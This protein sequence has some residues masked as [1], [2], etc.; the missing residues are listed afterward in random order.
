MR[1][2]LDDFAEKVSELGSKALI[3]ALQK[4][5][6]DFNNQL[7]EQ[8]GDNFKQLN[9]AVEKLV[10]WQQQYKDELDKLQSVQ[11]Q[12]SEDLA[13]SDSIFKDLVAKAASYTQSAESLSKLL[14][15]F[16]LQY[17]SM[18]Q[19]QEALLSILNSMKEVEP[20]FSK[21]LLDLTDVFKTGTTNITEHVQT[22]VK[23]LGEQLKTKNDE[24]AEIVK[25]MVPEI[26][27]QVNDQILQ[28]QKQLDENFK[29]LDANLEDELQK[30]L[31]GL[32]RQLAS[33]SEKF[34]SDYS[35][36]TEKL[37]KIVEISKGV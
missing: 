9:L 28:S 30:S 5:I 26:Q 2:S 33:L 14:T 37:R 31:S 18:K 8:F 6:S 17:E 12:S 27:K 20:S 22:Q 24:M 34:V 11:K 23:A 35:P 29:K 4:V 1:K 36:L 16:E 7:N 10:V 19:S 25:K 13:I 32:G 15:A 3:E 21:K